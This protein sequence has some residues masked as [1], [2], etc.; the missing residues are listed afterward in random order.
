MLID[1]SSESLAEFVSN[2]KLGFVVDESL[3]LEGFMQ[4]LT[5]I[6]GGSGG[7]FVDNINI[8]CNNQV[9]NVA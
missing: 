4:E 6:I 9:K 7:R 1:E 3:T 8:F 5:K 2:H